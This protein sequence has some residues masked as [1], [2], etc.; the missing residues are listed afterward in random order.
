M[1]LESLT[2]TEIKTARP[3][4]VAE[5]QHEAATAEHERLCQLL[6]EPRSIPRLVE[7]ALDIANGKHANG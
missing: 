2:A 3:D 6:R 5:L 7:R 4:L 1:T